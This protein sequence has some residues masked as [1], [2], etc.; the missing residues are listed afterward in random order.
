MLLASTIL[1]TIAVLLGLTLALLF[2][3]GSAYPAPLGRLHGALGVAGLVLLLL[4]LRE[5]PRG[6]A[7]GAGNFGV[8]AAWLLAA[9]LLFGLLMLH[10]SARRRVIPGIAVGTHAT[11]A[12]AG[13]VLLVVYASL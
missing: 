6:V 11:L 12:I 7:M 3:R 13:F 4:A 10:V 2:A 8:I 9:A 1:A 5:P